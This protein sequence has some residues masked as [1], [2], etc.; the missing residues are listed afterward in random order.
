MYT[1]NISKLNSSHKYFCIYLF[2]NELEFASASM[3][4]SILY[5]SFT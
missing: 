2:S 4:D 1:N 3:G 5:F